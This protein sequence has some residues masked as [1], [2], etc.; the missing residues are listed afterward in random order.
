ME[1]TFKITS[2]NGLHARPATLL[3]NEAVKHEAELILEVDGKQVNMKSIMGVMS[4]GVYQDEK[5]IVI[6]DGD[7]AEEALEA[8]KKVI[9][10]QKL[11][12]EI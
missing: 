2:E 8:I 3:V 11:G 10:T 1:R 6:A 12:R 5:I 9:V 7:D 4:L